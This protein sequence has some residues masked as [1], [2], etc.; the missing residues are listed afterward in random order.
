MAGVLRTILPEDKSLNR[1]E[2]IKWWRHMFQGS[3][4]GRIHSK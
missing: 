1:Q 4:E 2:E 3:G